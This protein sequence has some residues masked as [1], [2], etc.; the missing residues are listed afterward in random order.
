MMDVFSV[1]LWDNTIE[2]FKKEVA[3]W[4]ERE[5]ESIEEFYITQSIQIP[6]NANYNRGR[7]LAVGVIKADTVTYRRIC[8]IVGIELN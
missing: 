3:I 2:S 6:D 8:T 4:K 5:P 1:K 7:K